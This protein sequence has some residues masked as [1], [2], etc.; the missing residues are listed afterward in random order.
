MAPD[1]VIVGGGI[2][3]CA[4]ALAL[5]QKGCRVTLLE[6]EGWGHGATGAAMGHL[7]ILDGSPEELALCRLGQERWKELAPGLGT[8]LE[9]DVCGTLWVAADDEEMELVRPRCEAYR[10]AGIQAEL[11]DAAAL[12]E[13]E[14]CLASNL[15]GG[16]LVPGDAVIYPPAG[17]RLLAEAAAF[18]GADL[19]RGH[20]VVGLE[21][22]GLRLEDGTRLPSG[23][24]VLAAGSD[25]TRLLPDLPLVKRKGHLAITDRRPGFLKHQLVELGYLKSAHASQEDSVAFNLQPR[26][27]GQ[28]LL[29]SSRQFGD[30]SP[31]LRP[32]LFQ[33]MIHRALSYVP[34]LAEVPVLRTW[35]GFRPTTPDHRPLIGPWP[36]HRGVLLACGHEGLGI[37]TAPA[38]A[39]LVVAQVLGLEPPLDPT[40]YLPSRFAE[41]THA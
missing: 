17:A 38:T 25:S 31:D 32:Q 1:V 39:E 22:G 26:P 11:L 19:Q 21:R 14:P 4:C 37:T 41:A 36:H 6:A 23:C 5:A 35:T 20:R 40:P 8:P 9:M 12:R 30:E 18:A 16:M 2:V 34:G 10:A 28:L 33:R 29:G 15:A 24:V 7:V 27:N 3:G 13:L